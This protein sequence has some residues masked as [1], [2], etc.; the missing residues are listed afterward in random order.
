[1]NID[2]LIPADFRGCISIYQNEKM[3]F[4]KAYGYADLP[5]HVLNDLETRFATA[6]AGKVFVAIGILQ[7]IEKGLLHL[8]DKIG[9]FFDFD[10]EQID[11]EITVEQLLT[12]TSGI[13]DY[14]DESVMTE[15]EELWYD[16]PNYRIRSNKDLLPL[17]IHKPMMYPRGSKFQYNNTGFVVLAMILEKVTGMAFDRYLEES[18]FIPCK[19]IHTGYY[20]LDRQPAK[21]ASNYIFD[22]ERND[23]RTNIYSVD[24][25]GTGAGGA[26][27][28]IGDIRLFWKNLLS[29]QLLSPS[30]TETMLSNRSGE[31][32]CYGYGIWLKKTENDYNPYFQGCDPGVSF[33]SAFDKKSQILITIVSNYGDDVW[34]LWREVSANLEHFSSAKGGDLNES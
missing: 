27:T 4:E 29:Y 13:P 22:K 25:K 19:M 30:M 34:K 20:E 21:C 28:T 17:F 6:S 32:Q 26:F 7:L 24:A 16:F 12:H 14:F 3:L 9:S 8:G 2:K 5:N 1:M 18:I 15:Y 31:S 23:Y 33:K 10:L 11:A